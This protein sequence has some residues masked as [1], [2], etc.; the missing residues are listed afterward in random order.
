MRRVTTEGVATRG[1]GRGWTRR[2]L[3]SK[4]D[5]EDSMDALAGVVDRGQYERRCDMWV[6]VGFVDR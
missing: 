2:V 6:L 1:T 5:V 3:G 4:E